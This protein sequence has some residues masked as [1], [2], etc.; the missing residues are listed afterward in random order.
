MKRLLRFALFTNIAIFIIISLVIP[1][2]LAYSHSSFNQ[3]F[4]FNNFQN[5]GFQIDQF[6]DNEGRFNMILGT[7]IIAQ[8][9]K[10]NLTPL[11]KVDL[12]GYSIDDGKSLEVSIRDNVNMQDLT[13]VIIPSED[14]PNQ[15]SWFECDFPD[16]EVQP[17][18]TYYIIINQEGDGQFIW[19]GNYQHDYYPR[20]YAYS[21]Q[22][23]T[24]NWVNL[25][26]IFQDL[27]FC[28]KTYSYGDNQAPNPPAINGS[29]SGRYDENHDYEI[30]SIDPENDKVLYRVDWGDYTTS[31]WLG[32]YNSG[33]KVIIT[34]KW[35]EKGDY[36]IKVQS[37]DIYGDKSEWS[38]LEVSMPRGISI[39][40]DSTFFKILENLQNFI[41]FLKDIS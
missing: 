11:V 14:I 29:I 12:F 37:R 27:D 34:H 39:F 26:E 32:P 18:K 23:Y 6:Q 35:N 16:I 2:I 41:L 9:F 13:S 36:I 15:L 24:Q 22:E 28:F 25:S 7:F 4:R 31:Q 20:G 1:N 19:Y 17:D 21:N 40:H 8:S 5:I 3:D 38:T 10:P 33:E 30:Y